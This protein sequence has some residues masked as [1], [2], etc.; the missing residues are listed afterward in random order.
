MTGKLGLTPKQAHMKQLIKVFIQEH[1]YSPSYHELMDLSKLKSTSGVHRLVH[2][3]IKRGHA[4]FID[5]SDRS[6]N[7]VD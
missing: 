7:L 2:Q 5:G 4:T 6:I 3:L 1:G